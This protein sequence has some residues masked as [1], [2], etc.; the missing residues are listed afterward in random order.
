MPW[1]ASSPEGARGSMMSARDD[2]C[3]ALGARGRPRTQ[4]QNIKIGL[5]RRRPRRPH[6]RQVLIELIVSETVKLV[7]LARGCVVRSLWLP[8]NE[9]S[10][11]HP[12]AWPAPQ[13]F[14]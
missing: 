6:R 12:G 1:R 11:T 2:P 9:A 13:I 5:S 14:S 10:S 7:K 4:R 8:Y 3:G